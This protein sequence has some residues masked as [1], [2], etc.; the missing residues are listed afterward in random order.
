MRGLAITTVRVPRVFNAAT[1]HLNYAW[2][3]KSEQINPVVR[4]KW[5]RRVWWFAFFVVRFLL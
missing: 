1:E 4:S 5:R 2:A 3:E